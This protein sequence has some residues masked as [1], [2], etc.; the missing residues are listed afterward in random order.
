[1]KRFKA[2]G[3]EHNKRCQVLLNFYK[4]KGSKDY[5]S[6]TLQ[7]GIIGHEIQ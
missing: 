6:L 7:K 4:H 5:L 2:K 1:M 3:L